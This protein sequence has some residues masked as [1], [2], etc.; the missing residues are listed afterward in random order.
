LHR[1][2]GGT[3]RLVNI[4]AHKA[5]MLAYGE[6]LREIGPGLVKAAADD[7]PAARRPARLLGWLGR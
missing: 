1:F 7:T 5:L 4:L 6:G 2:S 3:P